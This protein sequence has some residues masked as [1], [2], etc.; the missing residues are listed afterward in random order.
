MMMCAFKTMKE[1]HPEGRLMEG[2]RVY[3]K[4]VDLDT[5]ALLWL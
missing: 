4:S 3:Q 1:T 5:L 2:F